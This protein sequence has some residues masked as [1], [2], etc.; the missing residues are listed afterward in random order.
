MPYQ[1]KP[2]QWVWTIWQ[3]VLQKSCLAQRHQTGAWYIYILEL[4]GTQPETLT[5]SLDEISKQS[6]E[7]V[8][9]GGKS[10][11]SLDDH[12]DTSSS[13]TKSLPQQV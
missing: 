12:G 3:E 1:E 6:A 13:I 10:I 4:V 2:L 9:A 5:V 11:E 7:V 8:C